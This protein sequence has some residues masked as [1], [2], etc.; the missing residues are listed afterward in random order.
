[1]FQ[2]FVMFVHVQSLRNRVGAICK[3][4]GPCVK[5]GVF[6]GHIMSMMGKRKFWARIGACD[7]CPRNGHCA[8]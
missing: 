4:I 7:M 3:N 2:A 5:A 1:M 6:E 8:I